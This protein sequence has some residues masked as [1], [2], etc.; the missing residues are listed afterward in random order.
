[1][2][3]PDSSER[4]AADTEVEDQ[5]ISSW[6]K[7]SSI[8][9]VPLSLGRIYALLCISKAPLCSEVISKRLVIS[10]GSTSTGL[11]TLQSWG[12]IHRVHMNGGR[13]A[14]FHADR[15]PWMWFQSCVRERHRN[16]QQ[17]LA[18]TI[19]QLQQR[20]AAG[21]LA[22]SDGDSDGGSM[23]E[24]LAMAVAFLGEL[25]EL[26]EVFLKV[27]NSP[28]AAIMRGVSQ[29]LPARRDTAEVARNGNGSAHRP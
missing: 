5:F 4:P 6:G 23:G 3:K 15:D 27:G 13:K 16:E 2:S 9:G 19:R 22:N 21:G 28:M 8:W 17:P 11:R 25:D 14:F 29:A 26:I 20:V 12:V 7:L 10:H 1:M 18:D 24:R